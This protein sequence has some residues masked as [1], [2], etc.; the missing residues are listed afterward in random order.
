VSFILKALK[1]VEQSANRRDPVIDLWQRKTDSEKASGKITGGL[2]PRTIALCAFFLALLISGSWLLLRYAPLPARN[3]LF[4]KP[5]PPSKEANPAN[6]SAGVASA[7]GKT[8][9]KPKPVRSAGRRVNAR[10]KKTSTEKTAVSL[11]PGQGGLEKK[12][13]KLPTNFNSIQA[14]TK[15]NAPAKSNRVDYKP[16]RS[17]RGPTH[18]SGPTPGGDEPTL[19]KNNESFPPA[20]ASSPLRT[21]GGPVVGDS[22]VLTGFYVQAI[23]WSKIPAER[24]AVINTKVVREGEFVEGM[25]VTRIGID[26]VSL[27]KGE[28]TWLVRC[29]R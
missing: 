12:Q 1:K 16:T 29:G 19:N 22:S 10:E 4:D 21:V 5:T 28:K 18:I 8:D 14:K 11:R 27:K 26:D 9:L 23:A 7:A 25:Q 13:R 17:K 2:R 15:P 20:A 24:I 3:S 6:M